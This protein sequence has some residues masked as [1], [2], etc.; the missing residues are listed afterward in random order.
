MSLFH[1]KEPL[2][3]TPDELHYLI[4]V[5]LVLRVCLHHG[6]AVTDDGEEHAH[7]A[8]LNHPHIEEEEERTQ[9]VGR[10]QRLKVKAAKGKSEQ[11]LDSADER[12]VD[13]DRVAKEL[14]GHHAE[15]QVVD[16]EYHRED[17]KVLGGIADGVAKLAHAL[18]ELEHLDEL[19][20]RQ[21]HDD[22]QHEAK[23]LIPDGDGH[24]VHILSYKHTH[25]YN[26][27]FGA[28]RH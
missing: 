1:A 13:V 15:G 23:Q 9:W 24:K 12:G 25:I 22:G 17:L 7:Q 2:D 26:I 21:E 20:G 8:D 19:D 10:P 4:V 6:K 18:V 3:F 28:I 27:L 5:A 16:Q 14:V 11:R